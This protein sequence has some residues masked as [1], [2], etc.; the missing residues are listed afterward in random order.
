M[1]VFEL[2]KKFPAEERFAMISPAALRGRFA[3]TCARLDQG[4]AYFVSKLTDCDGENSETDSLPET[5]AT[6]PQMSTV[7]HLRCAKKSARR[8]AA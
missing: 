3:L 6:S 1:R 8:S 2:S 7:R 5:A 4:E